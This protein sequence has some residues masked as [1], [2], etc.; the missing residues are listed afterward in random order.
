[1]YFLRSDRNLGVKNGTLG[2][3][4]Q[5]QD[6]K[7]VVTLRD[8]GQDEGRRVSFDTRQYEALDHGYAATVHKAQG[9]TVDKSYVLGSELYDRNV[10]N[11]AMT[12]HREGAGLFLS[13]ET[14][15]DKAQAFA[16]MAQ[17]RPKDMVLDYDR[18]AR[19]NDRM[20]RETAA[21]MDQQWRER[22]AVRAQDREPRA[23]SQAE[24]HD[25]A[26]RDE[27]I[28]TFYTLQARVGAGRRALE[29][30][31]T[32]Y[33]Q[34]FNRVHRVGRCRE[35]LDYVQQQHDKHAAAYERFKS[36]HPVKA[37]LGWEP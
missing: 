12:R 34:E 19:G 22:E 11:V 7:M 28:D 30:G 2:T 20:Q 9:V 27:R 14:G 21:R 16:R 24:I 35:S 37:A 3:I 5:L 17:E 26:G 25:K 32:T 31:R 23:P 10:I 4:E 18:V 29:D 6:G 13:G 36:D 33:E 8:E 15:T 1:M